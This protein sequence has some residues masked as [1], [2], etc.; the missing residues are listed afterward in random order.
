[1]S[2]RQKNVLPGLHFI[3]KPGKNFLYENIKRLRDIQKETQRK[4]AA[5]CPPPHQQF[6]AR[7]APNMKF[8]IA[9]KRIKSESQLE[10]EEGHWSLRSGQSTPV[11]VMASA[12][13]MKH[14]KVQTS[15]RDLPK[16][17]TVIAKDTGTTTSPS[18]ERH[19][20]KPL[21]QKLTRSV[22]VPSIALRSSDGMEEV[23]DTP[24][25]DIGANKRKDDALS[26]IIGE[27]KDFVAFNT[28]RTYE[29]RTKPKPNLN[30]T[31]KLPS[32]YKI[33]E[34][35]RYLLESK[36]E[37]SQNN[38]IEEAPADENVPPGHIL[39]SDRERKDQ[40]ERYKTAYSDLLV[41]LRTL[42]LSSD[43]LKHRQKKAA[44]EK[45]LDRL[46]KLMNL[47]SKPR[48]CL[49]VNGC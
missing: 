35:P 38:K 5:R 1:M 4:L 33:G 47:F 30:G 11:T 34:V 44:L 8:R 36:K 29:E 46:E 20:V 42:P 3:D 17:Q 28:Y 6:H 10:S 19:V 21:V 23:L 7:R 37:L 15:P 24:L 39:I 45:E 41:K 16:S 12:K 48:V 32:N 13:P 14:Q 18:I 22:S 26:S 40:L 2:C 9:Q 31:L 43:S 27:K 25:V 49:K